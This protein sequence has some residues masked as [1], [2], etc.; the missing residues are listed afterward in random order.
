MF[1]WPSRI[2]I[3]DSNNLYVADSDNDRIQKFDGM[4]NHLLT[5]AMPDN[6]VMD[7]V[8]D[9]DVDSEGNVYAVDQ[10]HY[11]IVKFDSAGEFVTLWAYGSFDKMIGITVVG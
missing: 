4:G 11:R 3:D 6:D 10:R 1:S 9:V 2:S 5:I 8:S 7:W